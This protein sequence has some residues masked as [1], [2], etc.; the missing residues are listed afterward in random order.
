MQFTMETEV[1]MR[2]TSAL[3][4]LLRG[5]AISLSLVL[6]PPLWARESADGTPFDELPAASAF[7]VRNPDLTADQLAILMVPLT[8]LR[9]APGALEVPL[10]TLKTLLNT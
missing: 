6:A 10:N 2:L 9:I 3:F 4:R 1:V 5:I 7:A 8:A